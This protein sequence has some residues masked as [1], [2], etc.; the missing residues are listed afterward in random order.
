MVDHLDHPQDKRLVRAVALLEV[1]PHGSGGDVQ[2]KGT[3]NNEHSRNL[4]IKDG[5]VA[6]ELSLC[7]NTDIGKVCLEMM[8]CTD[9]GTHGDGGADI[10]EVCLDFAK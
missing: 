7:D 4:D 3:G 5:H 1:Q 8:H 6:V 2:C 10:A 9:D